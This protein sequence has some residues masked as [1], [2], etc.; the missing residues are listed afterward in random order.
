MEGKINYIMT[1][2][3]KNILLLAFLLLSLSLFSQQFKVATLNC[4]WLSCPQINFGPLD[5]ILQ[6]DNIAQVILNVDADIIALQEVG[7]S[8]S[9]TTIDSLIRR[10]GSGWAGEIAPWR[11]DNCSQNQ[12]IIYKISKVQSVSSSLIENGVSYQ[13]WAS[14]RYPALYNVIFLT[15]ER[16]IPVSLINIHAKASRDESSYAQRKAASQEL[17]RLLDSSLYRDRRIILIGDYNDYLI[18]TSC[19]SCFPK[20]SPYKNFMDDTLNYKGLTQGLYD[21]Y[22][23]SPVIDNIIISDEL[24]ENYK[25]GSALRD[26]ASTLSINDY[27][28]TTTDHY[29]ISV[30]LQFGDYSDIDEIEK[31]PQITVFPNPTTSELT[32]YNGQFTINSV[33]IIDV[34]GKVILTTHYSLLTTNSIDVSGLANGIYILKI[35][36]EKGIFTRKF[37]KK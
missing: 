6:M 21:P 34:A 16:A 5:K 14:G 17:K 8:T 26:V 19:S 13:Y 2:K 10:L 31:M 9:Y 29:P 32:I 35:A 15:D 27:T 11:A 33:S 25:Y 7:T 4:E 20:D 30:L 24:F 22:W 3:I 12:A 1:N 37:V 18:G 36:T 23:R 28:Y